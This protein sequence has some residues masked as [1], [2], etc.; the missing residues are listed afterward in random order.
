MADGGNQTMVG[1]GG[2]VSVKRMGMGVALNA[3]SVVQ[4]VRSHVIARSEWNERR[5]N[6]QHDEEIASSGRRPP[7]NDANVVDFI[8]CVVK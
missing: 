6:L 8:D 3:S 4:D 2:G 1:V 5:S 7:R